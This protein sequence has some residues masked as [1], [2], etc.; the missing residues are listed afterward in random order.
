VWPRMTEWFAP[1]RD[2]DLVAGG[3]TLVTLDVVPGRMRR[4]RVTMPL[5]DRWERCQ[6]TVKDLHG[7]MLDTVTVTTA[8]VGI[9]PAQWQPVLP[10]QLL[11]L[12]ADLHGRRQ[13]WPL[14]CRDPATAATTLRFSLR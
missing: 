9:T 4:M 11:V 7:A 6:L 10:L 14:D 3:D 8:T 13:S 2:V 5:P 12:E 1:P